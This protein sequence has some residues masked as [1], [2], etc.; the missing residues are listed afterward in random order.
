MIEDLLDELDKAWNDT[1][2]P[3]WK[4]ENPRCSEID[5]ILIPLFEKMDDD[6]LL[7]ILNNIPKSKLE[8]IKVVLEY[9]VDTK[10]WVRPFIVAG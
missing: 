7:N 1:D 9:V 3:R 2:D 6:E 4:G 10:E 5:D 8:Q